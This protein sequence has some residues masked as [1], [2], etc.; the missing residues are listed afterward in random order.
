MTLVPSNVVNLSEPGTQWPSHVL[1]DSNVGIHV[2]EIAG[3]SVTAAELS[4]SPDLLRVVRL[5]RE[6]R[7]Q[8]ATAIVTPTVVS[9][10]LHVA[11]RG[12][13]QYLVRTMSSHEK[14]VRYGQEI[15]HWSQLYK[16]DGT[17]LSDLMT[18]L[19]ALP[20][21]LYLSEVLFIEPPTPTLGRA[22]GFLMELLRLSGRYGLDSSDARILL[23]AQSL[24][25]P[26]IV[27]LDRDMQRAAPDFTVYTWL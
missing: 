14:H 9:E 16:L 23:E 15:R 4:L 7:Q 10:M 3:L 11:T 17:I 20:R 1:L 6:L 22:D 25:I 26:H 13:C 24:G 12:H 18:K 27:S 21:I 5:I 19:E 8:R 2:L